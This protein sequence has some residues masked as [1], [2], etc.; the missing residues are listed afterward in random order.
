MRV[1]LEVVEW[2]QDVIRVRI[3]N[4][5]RLKRGGYYYRVERI[6]GPY[7]SSN[8]FMFLLEKQ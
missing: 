6:V 4:D 1:E 3:P 2:G 8:L 5:P 7:V